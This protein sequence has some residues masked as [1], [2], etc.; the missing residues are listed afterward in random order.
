MLVTKQE[1]ALGVWKFGKALT[2]TSGYNLSDTS[3]SSKQTLHTPSVHQQ[4]SWWSLSLRPVLGTDLGTDRGQAGR[5]DP[6]I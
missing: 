2:W 6:L 1:Q 4:H 3:R 5:G